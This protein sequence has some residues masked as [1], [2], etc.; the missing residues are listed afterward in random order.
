MR[1]PPYNKVVFFFFLKKLL[2]KSEILI[3]A[4]YSTEW[5]NWISS[6][7]TWGSGC[8][9]ALFLTALQK[10]KIAFFPLFLQLYATTTE[11]E[12]LVWSFGTG[13]RYVQ[14]YFPCSDEVSSFLFHFGCKGWSEY[15]FYKYDLVLSCPSLSVDFRENGMLGMKKFGKGVSHERFSEIMDMPVAYWELQK[16][17]IGIFI[18]NVILLWSL[19]KGRSRGP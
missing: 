17:E 4:C 15:Y 13:I 11:C 19:P 3:L 18:C 5:R 8:I 16:K 6:A 7:Q 10:L 2:I 12:G 14:F 9:S 1:V